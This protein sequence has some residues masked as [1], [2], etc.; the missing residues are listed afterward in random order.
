MMRKRKQVEIEAEK[1]TMI[2]VKKTK[3]RYKLSSNKNIKSTCKKRNTTE[4]D[5]I[6]NDVH[7]GRI[8]C[9][10]WDIWFAEH[11]KIVE[12]KLLEETDKFVPR[13]HRWNLKKICKEFLTD[14]DTSNYTFDENFIDKI[15]QNERVVLGM[16][17]EGGSIPLEEDKEE[18]NQNL[19]MGIKSS[20]EEMHKLITNNEVVHPKMEEMLNKL[21]FQAYSDKS[22]ILPNSFQLKN[23]TTVDSDSAKEK[24][25]IAYDS[26]SVYSK[27]DTTLDVCVTPK[28]DSHD[29]S[30]SN[31]STVDSFVRDPIIDFV[32]CSMSDLSPL[33]SLEKKVELF[34]DKG[35]HLNA[36]AYSV[37]EDNN[38]HEKLQ[39]FSRL[40][41]TDDVVEKMTFDNILITMKV[42][43][44]IFHKHVFLLC[45]VLFFIFFFVLKVH[46]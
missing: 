40:D 45:V 16:R 23:D 9:H 46:K 42:F 32:T 25:V 29:D 7:P 19:G 12:P 11:T 15:T 43:R 4:I 20:W 38:Q 22:E 35:V 30:D 37:A 31:D 13:A 21:Y 39:S 36:N 28:E 6:H 3:E 44:S 1:E 34:F 8:M 10:S 2:Q 41:D 27:N 18:K 26:A 5:Q 33:A 14:M 24:E 17:E